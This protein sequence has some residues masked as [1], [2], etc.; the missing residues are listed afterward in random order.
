ML[1]HINVHKARE[2]TKSRVRVMATSVTVAT[3][4]RET[5]EA[6][7]GDAA[8][9]SAKSSAQRCSPTLGGYSVLS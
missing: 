3:L 4:S 5:A 8:T 1:S 9:K 2:L 6:A 7:A